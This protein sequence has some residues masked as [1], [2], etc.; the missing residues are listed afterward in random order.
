[1]VVWKFTGIAGRVGLDTNNFVRLL[2]PPKKNRVVK[3]TEK[4][5]MMPAM[6]IAAGVESPCCF[7]FIIVDELY[8]FVDYLYSIFIYFFAIITT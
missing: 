1:M 3:K 4:P 7:L 2:E 8:I 5:I 6:M